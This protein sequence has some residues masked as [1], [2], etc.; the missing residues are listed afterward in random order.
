MSDRVAL[1]AAICAAPDDDTPR[2]VFADWLDEHNEAKRAA[3]IRADIELHRLRTADSNAA[4]TYRF[5]ESRDVSLAELDW[6][7]ADGELGELCA[8]AR[9]VEKVRL[10]PN[11]RRDNLPQIRGVGIHGVERGF[12]SAVRVGNSGKFLASADTIFRA[13]PVTTVQFEE[14]TAK[15]ARDSSRP[16]TSRA[17]ATSSSPNRSNPRPSGCSG[18]IATRPGCGDSNWRPG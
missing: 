2:L 5:F 16:A 17:S 3:R 7:A 12:L 11:S 15:H 9:A 13:A 8:A 10:V 14:L 6:S 4:A 1:L 18:T